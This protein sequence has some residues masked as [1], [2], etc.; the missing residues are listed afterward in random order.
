MPPS[1]HVSPVARPPLVRAAAV[2]CGAAAVLLLLLVAVAWAPLLAFDRV[3]VEGL[4]PVAVRRPALTEGVRVLSD[5]V[6]DPLTLRVLLGVVV[7]ALWRAGEP[8]PAALL[9][10]VCAVAAA[11]QQGMKTLVGRERPRL[12]D[13]VDSAEF[14]AF[15][16]GHAMTAAVVCGLLW[17][18]AARAARW[19]LVRPVAVAGAVSTAG[20]GLTRVYLG[21]HWPSDVLGGWLLGACLVAAAVAAYER[22]A[23]GRGPRGRR[24]AG[25]GPRHADD[26]TGPRG[27]SAGGRL[28][29]GRAARAGTVGPTPPERREV[30]ADRAIPRVARS[31]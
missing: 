13:P 11:V 2:G 4:H 25:P 5:W 15:P 31:A 19:T 23:A 10:G 17:W 29:G 3:V 27:A 28:D 7:L 9:A 1:A 12:P 21:V 22:W 18:A 30:I 26:W 8:G 20:V 24:R 16:S 14:A 6:W